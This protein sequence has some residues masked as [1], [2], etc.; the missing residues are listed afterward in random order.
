MNTRKSLKRNGSYDDNDRLEEILSEWLTTTS[1]QS[2]DE[3]IKALIEL[4]FIDVVKET[5]A[6]L[7]ADY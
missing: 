5:K 2:W 1:D 3:F 4:D 7:K 6:F